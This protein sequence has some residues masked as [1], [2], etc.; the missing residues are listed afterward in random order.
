MAGTRKLSRTTS[1]RIA[2]LKNLTTSL[3]LNGKI[4]TTEARA[5]EVKSIVD[6]LIDLAVKEKDNF[7]VKE[8]L[9]SKA[10]VDKNGKKVKA[11]KT[12]KNGRKYEVIQR[13]VVKQNVNVD[14]PSRLA[15]RKKMFKYVNKIKDEKG[16]TIDL[17]KK[18]FDEIAP[19]HDTSKGGYVRIVKL[20]PRKGDSAEM[21]QLE[22]L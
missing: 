3:L 13:E 2:M 1:H 6:S 21:A 11:T 19:K 7:E 20:V 14:K 22:I 12:S 17:T 15:A 16:N 18:L 8:K 10:K 5:K 4:Q 9:I